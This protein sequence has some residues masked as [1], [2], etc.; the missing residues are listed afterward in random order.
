[1]SEPFVI[2][3]NPEELMPYSKLKVLINSFTYWGK[4]PQV[5]AMLHSPPYIPSVPT[6]PRVFVSYVRNP[7]KGN[8]VRYTLRIYS[9][10]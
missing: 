2:Y 8:Q 3:R 7:V 1:M 9:S 6:N 4:S 5:R 10:D